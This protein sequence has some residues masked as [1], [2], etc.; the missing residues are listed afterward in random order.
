M[1]NTRTMSQWDMRV[2]TYEADYARAPVRSSVADEIVERVRN[3]RPAAILDAGAGQG[4]LCLRLKL[5]CPSAHVTIVDHSSA[6]LAR[7]R[8][9]L[10]GYDKVDFIQTE[11]DDLSSIPSSTI[12]YVISTFALHHIDDGRK[13]RM[14]KEAHRVLKP[15]GR[16]LIAD[17]IICDPQLTGNADAILSAMG[18]VFYPDLGMEDLRRKFDGFVEYPT[19]LTTMAKLALDAGFDAA[20][21][22]MNRMVA[23]LD[24]V[25]GRRPE[26]S[27]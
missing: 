4:H 23:V 16:L 1:E 15:H 25:P 19:D 27:I 3:A 14:L 12:E 6:M 22:V 17:E 7:A 11:L 26:N 21:R 18:E 20:F 13:L 24:A 5:A 9:R 10:A 2:E 8:Q